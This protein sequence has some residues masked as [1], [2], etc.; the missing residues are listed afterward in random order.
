MTGMKGIYVISG[1]VA[2]IVSMPLPYPYIL[3]AQGRILLPQSNLYLKLQ[4]HKRMVYLRKK[5][6]CEQTVSKKWYYIEFKV[7]DHVQSGK[8]APAVCN[9]VL[10]ETSR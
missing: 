6:F 1:N 4:E 10:P 8:L 3:K 9:L 7:N 2:S 5:G